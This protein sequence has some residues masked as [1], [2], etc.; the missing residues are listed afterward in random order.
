MIKPNTQNRIVLIA[1]AAALA[2]IF[3]PMFAG[4]TTASSELV[5][6][7]SESLPGTGSE[8]TVPSKGEGKN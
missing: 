2:G 8:V 1:F 3:F 4:K 6:K 7:P 5:A